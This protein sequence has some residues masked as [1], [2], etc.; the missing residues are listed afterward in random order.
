MIEVAAA[1]EHD[2]VMPF[3]LARSATSL[4]ISFA[5]ARLPPAS[6]L[7][8]SGSTAPRQRAAG[9]VVDHLRV[10]VLQA[11]EHGQTRTSGG[12]LDPF[13]PDAL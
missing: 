5:P 11:A 1:V 8:F 10:D 13:P 4:P 7:A 3:A 12:A 2:R 6:A 9:P